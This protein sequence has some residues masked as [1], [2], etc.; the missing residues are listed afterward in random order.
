VKVSI[1]MR[2]S[3]TS[4][5]ATS[6][7]LGTTAIPPSGQPA[8]STISPSR[9]ALAGVCDA[10]RTM[11]GFPAASAGATLWTTRLSGKL[12]GEMPTIGPSGTRRTWAVRPS[13]PGVQSS[14]TISP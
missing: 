1:L 14:G 4:G 10:G 9:S 13:M 6:V 12:N 7:A 3:S 8:S 11:I 2:S 5:A